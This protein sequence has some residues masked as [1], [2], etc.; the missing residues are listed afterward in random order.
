MK[1]CYLIVIFLAI[2]SGISAQLGARLTY[3]DTSIPYLEGLT[4]NNNGWPSFD[5]FGSG[6]GV[7]IDY[8]IRIPKKRIEFYPELSIT[9]NK[10]NFDKWDFTLSHSLIALA[11]NS[12]FYPLDFG[13]SCKCTSLLKNG[14]V[15]KKGFFFSIMT[16]LH[17]NT[18]SVDSGSKSSDLKP[19]LGF[20]IGLDLGISKRLLLSPFLQYAWHRNTVLEDFRYPN[21]LDNSGPFIIH[22]HYPAPSA[23]KQLKAGVR[24]GL[25]PFYE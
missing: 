12:H 14:N 6:Y 16:G 20:G 4:L 5:V 7:G 19:A 8:A 23:F 15:F 17:H 24:I 21:N 1:S 22:Y 10:E 2:S 13:N 25:Q 18:H 3:I 9:N 11:V